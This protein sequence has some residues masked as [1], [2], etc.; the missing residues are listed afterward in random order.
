ML[1]SSLLVLGGAAEPP[2][3]PAVATH[4][5]E[6]GA[7]PAGTGRPRR[8]RPGFQVRA[9][10]AMQT[11]APRQ[12]PVIAAPREQSRPTE[13]K[14]VTL[15]PAHLDAEVDAAKTTRL[16]VT[17]DRAMRDAGWSFCGGGPAFPAFKGK[18]RWESPKRIVVDVEL[19]PDHDYRLS[20]NCPAATNFRSADGVA[21]QPVPWSFSTLPA[22]LPDAAKQRAENRKALD[23]LQ[24]ALAAHYAYYDLRVRDWGKLVPAHE[25][26]IL[27]AKTTRGW[28]GQVARMLAAAEDIHVSVQLGDHRLPTGTRA[29][30]PLFRADLLAKYLPVKPAGDNG[31][32]GR[33]DDGIGY[34]MIASWSSGRDVDAVEAALADLRGCKAL[35]IDVRPNSGGDE[36]LAQRIAAW[37]VEGTKVYAKNRYRVRPGKDGFGP[38]LERSVRGNPEP[39]RFGKVPIAVLISRYV[40]SSNESFV[41]MLEQAPDCTSIGQR[42]YGSS[43]N[44][45]PHALPNGVVVVLPSWQDLRLDGSCFEG[46]G[47]APDV[48]VAVEPGELG[49]RDPV[50]ERA[51]A[52]LREKTK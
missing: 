1:I 49:A 16:V 40:M 50:L 42:T 51:L 11:L 47:L 23:A 41:M 35:V 46:E 29:V 44:P 18:P 7:A 39:S 19:E 14:V 9:D 6:V 28:A 48:E 12:L 26:A 8:C 13:P 15:E 22:K 5:V 45:K 43:G 10:L 20:L 33:T 52:V 21:L 25:P 38:V 36:R 17:F 32:Q 4:G 24:K 30:D 3:Q 37:F 34:L 31:L 27:A 2:A